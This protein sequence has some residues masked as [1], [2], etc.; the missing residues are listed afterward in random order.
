VSV[1]P[2]DYGTV[3]VTGT[4][5]AVTSARC[6]VARETD[7]FGTVHVHFPLRGFA[8]TEA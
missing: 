2:A 1:A 8:L 3:P 6:I 5:V 7:R 4:L